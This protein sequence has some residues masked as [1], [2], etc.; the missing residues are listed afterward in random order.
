M[1]GTPSLC[2]PGLAH[3]R[4]CLANDAGEG[5]DQ[6][7]RLLGVD[8]RIGRRLGEQ[9]RPVEPV[10][11]ELGLV[12]VRQ[13]RRCRLRVELDAP[14][15]RADPE[16]LHAAGCATSPGAPRPAAALVIESWWF[17]IMRNS[18]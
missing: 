14:R 8:R 1:T 10:G 13:P 3:Q 7:P 9:R 5:T 18:S 16:R 12:P 11:G 2:G 15:G 17:W 4:A 6:R